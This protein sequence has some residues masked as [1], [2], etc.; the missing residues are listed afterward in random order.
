M[1]FVYTFDFSIGIF[2]QKT[3]SFL[4]KIYNLDGMKGLIEK[5]EIRGTE[6]IKNIYIFET[7]SVYDTKTKEA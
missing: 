2:Y 4:K 7:K 5:F 6:L 3:L 1:E